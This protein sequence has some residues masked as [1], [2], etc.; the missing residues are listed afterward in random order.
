MA[1][2]NAGN[3]QPTFHPVELA[4]ALHLAAPERNT[5]SPR[6]FLTRAYTTFSPRHSGCTFIAKWRD[7]GPAGNS[8]IEMN[9]YSLRRL[10]HE[11]PFFRSCF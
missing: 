9:L 3:R 7:E 5:A 2:A 10:A 11:W 1:F 6:H 8:A 4:P